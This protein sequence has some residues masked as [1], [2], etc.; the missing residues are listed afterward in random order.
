MPHYHEGNKSWKVVLKSEKARMIFPTF[1][2][3]GSTVVAYDGAVYERRKD[4][5]L[6]RIDRKVKENTP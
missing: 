1:M 5:S 6:I 3:P 2:R 4:G